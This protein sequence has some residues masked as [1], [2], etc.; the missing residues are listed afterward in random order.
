MSNP[1]ALSTPEHSFSGPKDAEN[2]NQKITDVIMTQESKTPKNV[3]LDKLEQNND[4]FADFFCL[5][6]QLI[7]SIDQ[8]LYNSNNS[9][10]SANFN[11]IHTPILTPNNSNSINNN[12]NSINNNNNS[13]NNINNNLSDNVNN[14]N[15][16]IEDDIIRKG[17]RKLFIDDILE[18]VKTLDSMDKNSLK[19]NN[20]DLEITSTPDDKIDDIEFNLSHSRKISKEIDSDNEIT[21]TS[22]TSVTVSGTT[23][24]NNKGTSKDSITQDTKGIISTNTNTKE[25]PFGAEGTGGCGPHTVTEE[26]ESDEDE[27]YFEECIICSESMRNELKNEIG[28][29]D[30]CFHIFC[31]KCIKTWAD[32]T[33]LCPICR[34]EFT[35]IRKINLYYIQYLIDHNKSIINNNITTNTF[36]SNN[37]SVTVTGPPN[38]NGP[39]TKATEVTNINS[40]TNTTG[41]TGKRANS[42][43]TECTTP[44]KGANSMGTECTTEKI[45]NTFAVVTNSRE[46]GTFSV[47]TN[48]KD[49][50]GAVGA[51]T[52]TGEL[53]IFELFK[54]NINSNSIT[55]NNST[56]VTGGKK[57]ICNRKNKISRLKKIINV[58]RNWYD[59][60]PSNVIRVQK[61]KLKSDEDDEG[62]QICGNDDNWNQQLLCDICDKGYHTYCLNPPLTTIPETS[63]YCQLC[64]SNR[65]ELCNSSVT[66]TG[67]TASTVVP[68]TSNTTTTEVTN[69]NNNNTSTNTTIT[70]SSINNR[71]SR[72]SRR[73]SVDRNSI[74]DLEDEN[75][76]MRLNLL[77]QVYRNLNKTKRTKKS[78]SSVMVT[79]TTGTSTGTGTTRNRT[80]STNTTPNTNN[81][82]NSSSNKSTKSKKKSNKN[83][84]TTK[85][86]TSSN[87]VSTSSSSRNNIN[88]ITNVEE[89]YSVI[90]N[91]RIDELIQESIDTIDNYLI[92]NINNTPKAITTPGKGANYTFGTKGKGAN[93]TFSTMGKGANFM[94][95][96]CTTTNTSN[97]ST[98]NNNTR[99]NLFN[100]R[101][102]NTF[103]TNTSTSY[104]NRNINMR[105]NSFN[106][107]FNSMRNSNTGIRNTNSMRNNNFTNRN[108]N[109]FTNRNINTG[110]TNRNTN[111]MSMNEMD[112]KKYT[113]FIYRYKTINE[114]YGNSTSSN[115][116]NNKNDKSEPHINGNTV[117]Y[118]F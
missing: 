109:N 8:Y 113:S 105:N 81:N 35:Y 50:T 76:E 68:G 89:M 95:T 21:D 80:K 25:A 49:T 42:T 69:T 91:K 73:N 36:L 96:K 46:S 28:I 59:L 44:G 70:S 33:N 106:R 47:D 115:I 48:T 98:T 12:N 17:S 114:E 58:N 78:N 83:Q 72:S 45:P 37:S 94:G 86:S 100:T 54:Y 56:T 108:N 7:D 3:T 118:L 62:C 5:D 57:L 87:S 107:N 26:E 1:R 43:A 10:D 101:Y 4:S 99:M 22:N 67:T 60:I 19:N 16:E 31:F 34:R 39:G 110:Y 112:D 102:P 75:M 55:S 93:D 24:T 104:T 90:N 2:L 27:D 11:T 116:I 111:N 15:N 6:P 30:E 65:P 66:V 88:K 29:L 71:S 85:S 117:K 20:L 38:S 63:W 52:V 14:K 18:N 103:T 41:T 51:S 82:T 53:D 13:I 92:N 9:I 79:G 64:L 77:S 84:K 97:N 23:A 61:R 32:R 74:S 40:T